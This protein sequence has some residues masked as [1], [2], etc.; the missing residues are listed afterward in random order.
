MN[1]IQS[2]PK[3]KRAFSEKEK[4][5]MEWAA[6]K[7]LALHYLDR[8]RMLNDGAQRI[9]R[10]MARSIGTNAR[11]WWALFVELERLEASE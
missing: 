7:T 8:A 9:A 2:L 1:E 5:L 3:R 11:R 6:A 10:S 4:A